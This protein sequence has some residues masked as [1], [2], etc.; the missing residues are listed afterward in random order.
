[1]LN[2]VD[3]INLDERLSSITLQPVEEIEINSEL[4][5]TIEELEDNNK[6][7]SIKAAILFIDIRESTRLTES[8]YLKSMVKIYRSFMRMAVDCV[9][10]N[11]G[12]TRQFLGDRIMGVFIDSI[13]EDNNGNIE[14]AVDKA[15]N[16]A[17]SLQTAIDFSLNKHLK[18]NVND[19]IIECGIGI[20][21]GKVLITKVG[22]YGVEK[23]KDK[24]N[25]VNC[26]WVGNITNYASKYS[27]IAAGGEIFISENVYS[28][29]S[30]EYKDVWIQSKKSKGEKLIQGYTTNNYY[31]DFS[32]ELGEP[33][34]IQKDNIENSDASSQ[35]VEGIK[36]IEKLID[37]L[38]QKEKELAVIEDRLKKENQ[39]LKGKYIAESCA[40]DKAVDEK[41]KALEDLRNMTKNYYEFICK[42]IDFAHVKSNYIKY[43]T[44]EFWIFIIK[45]CYEI[46]RN[47]DYSDKKI[48]SYLECSLIDIYSYY[49]KY[50][51]AY[52]VMVVMAETNNH[53]LKFN[54]N[55]LEWAKENYKLHLLKNAIEK[56]LVNHT[57]DFDKRKDFQK[58]LEKIKTIRGF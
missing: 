34:K 54:E 58:Y 30:D 13:A 41:N 11:G 35:L 29:M 12:V 15:I 33:I 50:D 49:K 37:K 10:K 23:N 38:I 2:K 6:T 27:D 26:V 43:V 55:T 17:R 21:Y 40:K 22:M 8:S 48:T 53:W 19:K 52:E 36:E 3:F 57:I 47:L 31:L 44:E 56:R 5:L 9:R 42:I 45:K 1:M 51:K 39:E 28:E 7:Y 16:T 20:D 25:E 32:D 24:E 14:K 46:G 18:K 4:P